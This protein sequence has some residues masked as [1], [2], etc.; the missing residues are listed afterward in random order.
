MTDRLQPETGEAAVRVLQEIG[1]SVSMPLGWKCC[2]LVA[3]NAGD[4]PKAVQLAQETIQALEKSNADV[5]VSTS[6]SCVAMLL[7]D[8]EHIF[9]GDP[10]WLERARNLAKRVRT[11]TEYLANDAALPDD[12]LNTSATS[13]VTYHDACQSH[14]CLGLKDEAR[15]LLTD[16]MGTEI[17][18]M[19]ESSVC[20]GFGGTF[21]VEHPEVSRRI[22]ERKLKNAI[23][24]GASTIVSDNPGCIMHIRGALDALG[25]QV[26]V[27]HLAESMD[28]A[29]QV[30]REIEI[31]GSFD[32]SSAVETP[33]LRQ[34]KK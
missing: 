21:S 29:I 16:V 3:S 8:Y 17:C 2:G 9:D 4:L 34:T 11:F 22:L 15:H 18:E 14:N 26:Q 10:V 6:S 7:Q 32:G 31:G 12:A 27:K 33:R 20:C 13:A 19:T 25:S 5:V 23:D 1:C 28:D 30:R 24:S